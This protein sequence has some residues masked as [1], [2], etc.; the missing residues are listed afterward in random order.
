MIET[1]TM[2]GKEK[3]LAHFENQDYSFDEPFSKEKRQS[4][5]AHIE[6]LEFPTSKTEYWKYTRVNKI[7]KGDYSIQF[8]DEDLEMDIAVPSKNCLVFINGFFNEALSWIEKSDDYSFSSLSEAKT[9]SDI[10]KTKFGSISKDSSEIFTA[11]NT[12]YHQDGAFLHLKKNKKV[13]GSFYIINVVS[14]DSVLSNPR[15]FIYM[16]SGSEANVVIK[17][18]ALSNAKS[19]TNMVSE[20]MVEANASLEINKIQDE[21]VDDFQISNEEVVQAENSRFKINT[22]TF[23]GAIVRNNLNIS[24]LGK[25]TETWLNGLY[26]LKGKQHV[27]NHSYVLHREPN[28]VSHEL[29]KGIL[30]EQSTGV[31]NGKVFVHQD[32]QKTNAYQSNANMVLSDNASAN[33][34]PEL[35][36][37]ADDV[38]CS[39]GSV[40]GQIDEEALFYLRSRGMSEKSSRAV[41]LN[42]F[43][44]DVIEHIGVEA[45]KEE[46]EAFIDSNFQSIK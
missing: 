40:T 23:N 27:D 14:D 29:Y 34:K 11:I 44:S 2:T 10:L 42:A 36:I 32:A 18:L 15:N 7:I 3:F 41:L 16:E 12:A 9:K 38:K 24:L 37:Y 28:C 8:N 6:D 4:A 19:F 30:D 45:V 43:A 26:P 5:K 13:D 22:F 25:S 46:I 35:E 17:T 39:H 31:F 21:S 33:S 1:L 20:I